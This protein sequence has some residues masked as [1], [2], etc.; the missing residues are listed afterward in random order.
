MRLSDLAD[1]ALNEGR[2]KI[3]FDSGLAPEWVAGKIVAAL[4]KGRREAVIGSDAKW[5][6]RMKRWFPRL[7]D[8][9]LARRVRKLYE[10]PVTAGK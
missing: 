9:L 1:G 5:M 4:R 3:D 10:Q 8:R 6:L 2:A 7:L